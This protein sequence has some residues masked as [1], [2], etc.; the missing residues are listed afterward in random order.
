MAEHITFSEL[1]GKDFKEISELTKPK[2]EGK[3]GK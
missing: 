3:N 2:G 1:E